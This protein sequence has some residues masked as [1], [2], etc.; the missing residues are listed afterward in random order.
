[1]LLAERDTLLGKKFTVRE[2]RK[3]SPS[4]HQTAILSTDFRKD[5]T[6]CAAAMFARWCQEN[7]FRYMREHYNLDRLVDYSTGNI[8]GSTRVINPQY[9]ELDSEVRKQAARLTRKRC[10][11]NAIVLCDNIEPNVV[12]AYETKKCRATARNRAYENNPGRPESLPQGNAQT[13]TIFRSARGRQVPH[14]GDEKQAF[15]R[16]D[17][18][19]R[20]SGRVR[21]DQYRTPSH[22]SP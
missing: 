20:L 7:F 13:C 21:H 5:I 19:H 16:H 14:V 6:H 4:G 15:H 18:T 12:T 10:E 1:M 8:P 3:L 17:Q 11:C 22:V 9:R 2:I